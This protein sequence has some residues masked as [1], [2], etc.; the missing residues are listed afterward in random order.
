M[1]R[2]RRTDTAQVFYYKMK[3]DY[4][5]YLA[6]F[7]KDDGRTKASEESLAAYKSATGRS[8]GPCVAEV[9][10]DNV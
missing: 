6:E 4:F 10:V 8:R 1:P 2:G 9:V 7:E 3:G 5:R